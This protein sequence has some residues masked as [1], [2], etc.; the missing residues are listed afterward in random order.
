M[1][2][3]KAQI[4]KGNMQKFMS[5]N[6]STDLYAK[7]S[8]NQTKRPIHCRFADRICEAW[9]ADPIH[10]SILGLTKQSLDPAFTSYGQSMTGPM[11]MAGHEGDL[12][13]DSRVWL[14]IIRYLCQFITCIS[15]GF[16]V[17]YLNDF[18]PINRPSL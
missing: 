15:Q 14:A 17:S 1:N 10:E 7:R 11:T 13:R 8:Q 18:M 2:T 12:R 3:R 5:K 9:S 4:V 16:Y 6:T